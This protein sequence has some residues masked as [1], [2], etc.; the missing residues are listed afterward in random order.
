MVL[1]TEQR[2]YWRSEA[3]H[4]TVPTIVLPFL[5]ALI[6]FGSPIGVM[7]EAAPYKSVRRLRGTEVSNVLRIATTRKDQSL[8]DVQKGVWIYL[9]AVHCSNP[10]YD[11]FYQRHLLENQPY[12]PRRSLAWCTG[13]RW[14]RSLSGLRSS[15]GLGDRC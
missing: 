2:R 3:T 5:H 4:S 10:E 15:Q 11:K 6:F 7:N 9:Y 1:A 12:G 13:K 8:V 14:N